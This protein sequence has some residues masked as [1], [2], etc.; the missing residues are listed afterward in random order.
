MISPI[1]LKISMQY[2]DYTENSVIPHPETMQFNDFYK[3]YF[4]EGFKC[5]VMFNDPEDT[6]NFVMFYLIGYVISLFIL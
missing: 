2:E 5:L 1:V 6:C 4:R 3:I